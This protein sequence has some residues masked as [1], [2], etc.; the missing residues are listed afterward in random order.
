[1]NLRY[2][3]FEGA[4]FTSINFTNANYDLDTIDTISKDIKLIL[5]MQGK[6]W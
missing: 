5:E 2:T 1:V 4:T 3:N 6:L